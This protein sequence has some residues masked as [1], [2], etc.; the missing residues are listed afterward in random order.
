MRAPEARGKI[1]EYL[2]QSNIFSH[3]AEKT[4]QIMDLF[5]RLGGGG[6]WSTLSTPSLWGCMSTAQLTNFFLQNLQNDV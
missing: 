5:A 2:Q 4:S 1:L 6:G 3:L